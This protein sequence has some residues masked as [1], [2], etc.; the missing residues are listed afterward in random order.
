MDAPGAKAEAAPVSNLL[1]EVFRVFPLL[2]ARVKEKLS[3]AGSAGVV[4]AFIELLLLI[5][6]LL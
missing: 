1:V 5:A 2:H 6:N 3:V 4:T